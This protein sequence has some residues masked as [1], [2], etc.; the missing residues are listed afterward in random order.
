MCRDVTSP[1]VASR[2]TILFR[3]WSATTGSS[4]SPGRR[5]TIHHPVRPGHPLHLE[6]LDVEVGE[7]PAADER[8]HV[9]V[10]PA[11]VAE[12][13]LDR[14]EPPLP[15]LDPEILAEAMFEEEEPASRPQHPVD[16]AQCP[17][18]V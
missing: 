8:R 14:V 9:E 18:G 2:S 7:G 3:S 1:R 4:R 6:P 10:E 5:P 15:P 12:N 13:P 16:L 17:P 11:P